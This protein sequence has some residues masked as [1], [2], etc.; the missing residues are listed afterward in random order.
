MHRLLNKIGDLSCSTNH[1]VAQSRNTRTE[2]VS[3]T[4]SVVRARQ[5]VAIAKSSISVKCLFT[6]ERK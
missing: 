5:I 1:K 2:Y 4:A 3:Q 6:N